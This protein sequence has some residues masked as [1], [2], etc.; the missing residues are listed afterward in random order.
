MKPF[1]IGSQ[2]NTKCAQSNHKPGNRT[3]RKHISKSKVPDQKDLLVNLTPFIG[4]CYS[5]MEGKLE[6]EPRRIGWVTPSEDWVTWYAFTQFDPQHHMVTQKW[7]KRH[8]FLSYYEVHIS[9]YPN[10]T[11]QGKNPKEIHLLPVSAYNLWDT[12]PFPAAVSS[13][14]AL[15]PEFVAD[16]L[17]WQAAFSS[18][19]LC[20][21]IIQVEIGRCYYLEINYSI[22]ECAW[23]PKLK[24]VD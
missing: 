16:R 1:K 22:R 5:Q 20:N 17:S 19:F 21:G 23:G 9:G 18:A 7:K 8:Y 15:K 4:F 2:R 12:V 6:K 24:M 11:Y 3:S 10:Q 14:L 13:R